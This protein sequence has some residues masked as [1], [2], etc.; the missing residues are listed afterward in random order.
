MDSSN[1][2]NSKTCRICQEDENESSEVLYKPCKCNSHVHKNCLFEWIK[3]KIKSD[4]ID[5][6]NDL[7]C[8]VCLSKIKYTHTSEGTNEDFSN[9]K[10]VKDMANFFFK[11]N[12]TVF[13][14]IF[15][16]IMLVFVPIA[17]FFILYVLY[18]YIINEK[19]SCYAYSRFPF[20]HMSTSDLDDEF[21]LN[22]ASLQKK[23]LVWKNYDY[24]PTENS[25]LLRTFGIELFSSLSFL[26]FFAKEFSKDANQTVFYKMYQYQYGSEKANTELELINHRIEEV[27]KKTKKQYVLAYLITI[28]IFVPVFFLCLVSA[29]FIPRYI[30][31]TKYDQNGNKNEG[32]YPLYFIFVSSSILYLSIKMRQYKDRPISYDT[33]IFQQFLKLFIEFEIQQVCLQGL[34]RAAVEIFH[35]EK[36]FDWENSNITQF[37]TPNILAEFTSLVL[38]SLTFLGKN[39][40]RNGSLYRFPSSSYTENNMKKIKAALFRSFP[41]IIFESI[42]DSMLLVLTYFGIGGFGIIAAAY[43][44]PEIFPFNIPKENSRF[45]LFK[46]AFLFIVSKQFEILT[47]N[48][49]IPVFQKLGSLFRLSNYLF[50]YDRPFERGIVIYRKTV[51]DTDGDRK[52]A[53]DTNSLLLKEPCVSEQ[54]AIHRLEKGNQKIMA[55]LVQS[56]YD[57]KVPNADSIYDFSNDW[58]KPLNNS[59]DV[60][61]K[62]EAEDENSIPE[63]NEINLSILEHSLANYDSYDTCFLPSN[64][65][66]RLYAYFFL[67]SLIQN[68]VV[69]IYIVAGYNLGRKIYHIVE[70][71]QE[72]NTITARS[73][74]LDSNGKFQFHE[75]FSWDI[76]APIVAVLPKIALGSSALCAIIK[77]ASNKARGS[78][79]FTKDLI[80]N[81]KKQIS[82]KLLP[83]LIFFYGM[84][85]AV[86]AVFSITYSYKTLCLFWNAI[87]HDSSYLTGQK[88]FLIFIYR[89]FWEPE[90]LLW[91]VPF[92]FVILFH[93]IYSITGIDEVDNG[94]SS[95]MWKTLF[96]NIVCRDFK[97]WFNFW[98][99]PFMYQMTMVIVYSIIHSIYYNDEISLLKVRSLQDLNYSLYYMQLYLLLDGRRP[100]SILYKLTFLGPIATKV[101]KLISSVLKAKWNK[102]KLITLENKLVEEDIVILNDE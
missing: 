63:E 2:Q 4:V 98:G 6:Q 89:M 77:V 20:T 43:F 17:V 93:I 28:F 96:V 54:E 90:I 75:N 101:V 9:L 82:L 7:Q 97:V 1:N 36:Y 62:A 33:F 13:K 16:V 83:H 91:L 65:K 3:T 37:F 68:V 92:L 74:K 73:S 27:E 18:S 50:D 38:N 19:R 23:C 30:L 67:I 5:Y 55:Y 72:F 58:F 47:E 99:K 34:S 70:A 78:T 15:S 61:V 25:M 52:H 12:V 53:R 94:S 95:E 80:K 100:L 85:S 35:I 59:G 56:G 60:I 48:F 44:K 86:L 14:V 71:E 40:F 29:E 39:I 22:I 64:F 42:I 21:S 46:K 69:F 24:F 79:F 10:L 66:L 41:R 31:N 57:A 76:K 81:V 11:R 102:W 45:H 84:L 26:P 49:Y 32:Y 8:E 51:K 87:V 88:S